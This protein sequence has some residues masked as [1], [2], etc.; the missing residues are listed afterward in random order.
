MGRKDVNGDYF[1]LYGEIRRDSSNRIAYDLREKERKK[2][3]VRPDKRDLEIYNKGLEWFNNGFKLEDAPEN[4]RNNTNF[5]YEFKKGER[6]AMI[7]SLQNE[8][9]KSR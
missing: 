7:E 1:K 9:K 8:S 4:F 3:Y 5:I 2:N 6:L